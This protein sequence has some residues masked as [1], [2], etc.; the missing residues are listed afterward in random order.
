MEAFYE[1]NMAK[2]KEVDWCKLNARTVSLCRKQWRTFSIEV[3]SEEEE[4]ER[5]QYLL[6]PADKIS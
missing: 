1:N 6:E 3:V 4:V 2:R 5:L